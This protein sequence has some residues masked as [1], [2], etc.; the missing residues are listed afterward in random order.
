MEELKQQLTQVIINSKL[1]A[2]CIYYIV[3]DVYRD[4]DNEYQR[5]LISRKKQAAEE[6]A[7]KEQAEKELNKQILG[8]EYKEEE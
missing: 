6:A 1:P 8:E 4:L 7:F 3:K 2:E 5:I